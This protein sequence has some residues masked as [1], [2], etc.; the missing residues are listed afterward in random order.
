MTILRFL[1]GLSLLLFFTL[2]V[3]SQDSLK[4][5]LANADNDEQRLE[6]LEGLYKEYLAKDLDSS[7]YYTRQ[8]I[9]L[10]DEMSDLES[11]AFMLKNAGIVNYY[12]GDYIQ[13]L[14][15]W[16]SSLNLFREI[17]HAQGESNLLSNLG[18]VYNQ[19]GD[20]TKAIDNF[21]A[22]LRIAE[23]IEDT[24]RVATLYQ[25]LG[26]LYS[27]LDEF[28]RSEEY[29]IKAIE[30]CEAIDYFECVG[31]AYSNLSEVSREREDY[32]QARDYTQKAIEIFKSHDFPQLPEALVSLA[33][34][35]NLQSKYQQAIEETQEALSVA[36]EK[37]S[38]FVLPKIYAT[39]GK[40]WNGLKK[41]KKGL[42]A[43]ENAVATSANIGINSDLQEAYTGLVESHKNLN[44]Y[45]QAAA[46]QDSLISI[47]NYI[48]NTE[49]DKSISNLEL[50]YNVEK[51]ESEIALLNSEIEKS[52]LQRN[53]LLSASSFLLILIGGVGFLY[54]YSRKKNRVIKDEKDKSDKLLKNILPPQT[55]EE[56]KTHGKVMPKRH[57]FTTV[58]FTDFVRFTEVSA[59]HSPE[60]IVS[61]I[62][63]YFKEFDRIIQKHGLEK[64]KTIGDAY[65][66]AGG[67]HDQNVNS[68]IILQNTLAAASDIVN[69]TIQAEKNPP[70]EGVTFKVRVGI[71]SGPV[72]AGVVG[73]TKFQYDIWGDTVNVA[74]RMETNSEP[75]E[76]NVSESVYNIVNDD[77]SFEYRGEIEAKHS[78]K[79]KMYYFRENTEK[80]L[81]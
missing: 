45:K 47:N 37:G 57:E 10:A 71:N 61:S 58:L 69:F 21:L 38:N 39:Q 64:I 77:T 31:L 28:D 81:N 13:V 49:K 1:L 60:V 74:S 23:R 5:V 11:K 7:I 51:K 67:L 55:A 54:R 50:T 73:Q 43:Y 72:V 19:T 3:S 30:Q 17:D 41:Y 59:K 9:E 35:S 6:A 15:Y 24:L 4:Q 25:N 75:N 63:Y 46:A 33:L 44:N 22:S 34:I 68:Q 80:S 12:K 8:A 16:N 40:S 65:M 53:L 18:S 2:S 32:V 79:L 36:N 42:A 78:G 56:L 27:N 52:N 14:E 66:C 62:D 70:L 76:I 20:Y 48:Y 26:A 29:Y